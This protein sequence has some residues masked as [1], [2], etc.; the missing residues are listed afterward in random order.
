MN[1]MRKPA[2]SSLS[3]TFHSEL[4]EIKGM[5]DDICRTR[6][7]L[8]EVLA[9]MRTGRPWSNNIIVESADSQNVL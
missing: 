5:V 8:C 7:E 2:N 1:M 6:S 9:Q 3:G 4:L